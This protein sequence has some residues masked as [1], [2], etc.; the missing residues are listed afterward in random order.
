[1]SPEAITYVDVGPGVMKPSLKVSHQRREYVKEVWLILPT[2][3]AW[4]VERCLVIGMHTVPI[5]IR[6]D[7]ILTFAHDDQ[8]AVNCGCEST[9]MLCTY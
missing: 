3:I 1:M 6:Q 7:P 4:E 8:A 5:R 2:L 9:Y